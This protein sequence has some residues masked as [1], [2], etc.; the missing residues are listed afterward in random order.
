MPTPKAIR[1]IQKGTFGTELKQVIHTHRT[2]RQS[3]GP[4]GIG[5][6]SSSPHSPLP[7]INFRFKFQSSFLLNH[8]R[9]GPNT[10]NPRHVKLG[11]PLPHT[12]SSKKLCFLTFHCWISRS[13]FCNQLAK[14][15]IGRAENIPAVPTNVTRIVACSL[16]KKCGSEPIRYLTLYFRDRRFAASLR[17]RN[18]AEIT[19]P[20]S[21]PL[22]W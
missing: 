9:F 13:G 16:C 4:I 5:E 19:V 12:Y 10:Y 14:T 1:C 6:L 17:F 18:R 8:F 7:N 21:Y 20:M 2:W 11:H 3:G 15:K 22:K